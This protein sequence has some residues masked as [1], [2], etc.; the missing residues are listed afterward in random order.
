MVLNSG[1]QGTLEK[2]IVDLFGVSQRNSLKKIVTVVPGEDELPSNPLYPGSTSPNL[3][4][5]NGFISTCEHGKGRSSPDRQF[6]FVNGRPCDY[7]KVAKTINEV[8]HRFNRHQ[9]PFAVLNISTMTGIG[10]D[11]NVTP[12]KRQILMEHESSLL[13]LIQSSM[14]S[15]FSSVPSMFHVNPV[16]NTLSGKADPVKQSDGGE[17]E[18]TTGG[19]GGDGKTSFDMLKERLETRY[20]DHGGRP[21]PK[22]RKKRS[23][24]T[25]DRFYPPDTTPSTSNLATGSP[26]DGRQRTG[27]RDL[28]LE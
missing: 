22:K 15:L 13:L 17:E 21:P 25:L 6:L 9:Y 5:L 2:H 18:E 12:D 19:G 26:L 11:V 10:V 20:K 23:V 24:V 28:D 1:G 27:L 7:N 8:Y 4:Q 3:F 16:D 14:T